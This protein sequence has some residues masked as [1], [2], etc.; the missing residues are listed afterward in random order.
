MHHSRRDRRFTVE[1][2]N[3]SQSNLYMSLLDLSSDGSVALVYPTQGQEEFIAPGKTW[4]KTLVSFA[5]KDRDSVFD[6]L[7]LVA[8]TSPSDF[9]FL[10]QDAVREAPPLPRVQYR[11]RN[12]LE[13]LLANAAIG[14]TRG[15]AIVKV[16][17][18]VTAERVLE[19]RR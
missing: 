13:Q 7:K 10:Q 17:D 8:T 16:E 1:V 11:G 19:V 5:P 14:T 2:T 18:W 3:N 9:G 6:V 4:N 15:V 12:P